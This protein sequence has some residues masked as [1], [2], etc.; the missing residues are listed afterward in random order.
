MV[1]IIWLRIDRM[2]PP[3]DARITVNA[4]STACPMMLAMY[5]R[6][7]P[8]V[9]AV[10]VVPVQAREPLQQAPRLPEDQHQHQGEKEVRDRLEEGRGRQ[11]PVEP[12]NRVARP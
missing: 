10:D 7:M 8:G 4:G 5:G 2:N 6:F 12:A 11:Q 3:I 1:V 9:D